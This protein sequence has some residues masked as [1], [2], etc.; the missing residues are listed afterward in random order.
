MSGCALRR[1]GPGISCVKENETSSSKEMA[2][3]LAAIKAARDQQDAMWHTPVVETDKLVTIP[4]SNE[5]KRE[6]K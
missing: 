1:W 3:A 4:R 5:K 2:T 6:S